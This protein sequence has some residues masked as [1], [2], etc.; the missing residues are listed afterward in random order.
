LSPRPIARSDNRIGSFM[1]SRD[2]IPPLPPGA[3]GVNGHAYR[4]QHGIIL[5]CPDEKVQQQ[6]FETLQA[7]K[8]CKI[9]VVTT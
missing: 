2:K 6:V 9:K 7:L 1:T 8:A 5:V 3:P 4:P